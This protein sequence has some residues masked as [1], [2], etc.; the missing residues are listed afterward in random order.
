[1]WRGSDVREGAARDVQ[2]TVVAPGTTVSGLADEISNPGLRRVAVEQ[3]RVE[4]VSGGAV[5]RAVTHAV[6]QPAGVDVD[7]IVV[8]PSARARGVATPQA[9]ATVASGGAP[10]RPGAS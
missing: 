5:A 6:G 10:S 4:P 9:R 7:E 2:V 8:R 1:M 3:C